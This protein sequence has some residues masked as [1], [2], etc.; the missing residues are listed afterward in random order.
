MSVRVTKEVVRWALRFC[1]RG[2]L[3][4][5]R[6][7]LLTASIKNK[8]LHTQQSAL[9]LGA[10]QTQTPL[11]RSLVSSARFYSQDRTHNEDSEERERL[12]SSLPAEV[13]SDD[14]AS[15]RPSWMS[16]FMDRLQGCGSPSDVLDLT[17]EHS[18]TPREISNCLTHMWSC[19]KKLTDEQRR[20][21]LRL[22]FEHHAFDR[23][24]Q[25]AMKNVRLVHSEDLA[26][27][28]ISMIN[29]GVPQG[30]RVVQT[31]LRACQESLNDFDEKGLSILAS[32]LENMEPSPN[33]SALKD[34]MRLVV[35]AQ[36]PTIQSVMSLQ[37]MMRVLGKDTPLHLKR[38]LEAKAV[39]MKDQFSLPNS[40]HM[41]STMVTL[42]FHSKP[43]LDVCTNNIR[44]NLNGIPFNRLFKLLLSCR[45][46]RYR[47]SDL[48]KDISDYVAS[49]IYMWTNKQAVLFLFVFESLG[50]CPDALMEEFAEK[51]IADPDA[52]TLKDLLCVL[53]VYSS[54]N[55]DLQHRRQQFLDSLCQVLESYLPKMSRFELLRAV[56]SLCILGH[57]PSAPLEKLLKESTVEQLQMTS[58]K[59][60]E[61]QSRLLWMLDLCLRLDRPALSRPLTVPSSSLVDYTPVH[62]SINSVLSLCLRDVLGD[63]AD[64][65]LEEEVVVENMY[66]IDA[67]ITKPLP[68]QTPA[69][70]AASP[71]AESSQR[72]AVLCA[73]PSAVCFG[74]SRP[75]GPLAVR[76][77]HLRI[78]GYDP[79]MVTEQGLQFMSEEKRKE[80][81]REQIYPEHH[82]GQK[83]PE[84]E[85]L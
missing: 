58:P 77:R 69:T 6:S 13:Q 49:V 14:P 64:T 62:P 72:I 57:F 55:Y 44:E 79:V 4:H 61:N 25:E 19:M 11:S 7:P 48:F 31:F 78:L 38:K 37:T 36:L 32:C 27:S 50:F 1:S 53:K 60:L 5:H 74:T 17:C 16:A 73:P 23:L 29:L 42:G 35:E 20:Y 9:I 85:Q 45:D 84:M 70:E 12:S 75:R 71:P 65:I 8:S 41:I 18:P 83:Q 30:S 22:M 26:Y 56:F 67:V 28:L 52:L 54:L 68:N 63:E 46:L 76:I 43:L 51:V 39:S 34:G 2:S 82:G 40:L 47:D 59:F 21:E 3:G 24:L 33:V 81:L 15:S 66:F 10:R 80:F